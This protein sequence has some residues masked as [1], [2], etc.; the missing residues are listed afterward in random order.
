MDK[1]TIDQLDNFESYSLSKRFWLY[2]QLITGNTYTVDDENKEQLAKIMEVI[3]AGEKG[4]VLCGKT[5]SGKTFIF[6]ILN[7]I[8]YPPFDKRRIAVRHVDKVIS[9]YNQVG[10]EVF[11]QIENLNICFDELGREKIGKY[12]GSECDVMQH[13]IAHRYNQFKKL[14]YLTYFT[15]NYSK[16]D[17]K[18]RYGE[19]SFSRLN[20]MAVFI[21]LGTKA[22][23]ADRRENAKKLTYNFPEVIPYRS[24]AVAPKNLDSYKLPVHKSLSQILKEKIYGSK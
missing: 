22:G 19:H 15:T 23:H 2:A 18:E 14:N 9:K 7:K 5:G 16:S 24:T 12:F 1:I 21:N 3:A 8:L 4:I 6:E 17:L 13:L 20:E 11:D 10:D